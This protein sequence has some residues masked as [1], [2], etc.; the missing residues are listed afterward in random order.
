[1][2]RPLGQYGMVD[3]VD[4]VNVKEVKVKVRLF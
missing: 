3:A 1:M 2:L 4:F